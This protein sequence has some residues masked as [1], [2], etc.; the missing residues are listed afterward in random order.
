MNENEN[1]FKMCSTLRAVSGARLLR[2]SALSRCESTIFRDSNPVASGF[3]SN[4]N[5]VGAWAV[6]F[7]AVGFCQFL[8]PRG[9]LEF[10]F[11]NLYPGVLLFLNFVLTK[12]WLPRVHR[13]RSLRSCSHC[14]LIF[15]MTSSVWSSQK[16]SR[17]KI[18][19]WILC[20]PAKNTAAI[21]MY[22]SPLCRR[23]F[24]FG[25]ILKCDTAKLP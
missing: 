4:F 1:L 21:Q 6:A 14:C 25:Q 11:K 8:Y 23:R 15:I 18:G 9:V 10:C 2:K 24:N 12:R 20:W 19:G 13:G 5:P 7:S 16:N 17:R 22:R 3:F